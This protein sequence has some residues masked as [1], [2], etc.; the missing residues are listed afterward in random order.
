VAPRPQMLKGNTPAPRS[1]RSKIRKGCDFA[2][3]PSDSGIAA[4]N[5]HAPP[6]DILSSRSSSSDYRLLVGDL[7]LYITRPPNHAIKITPISTADVEFYHPHI[8]SLPIP[9]RNI[10]TLP[11]PQKP[12][13]DQAAL[14]YLGSPCVSNR[15]NGNRRRFPFPLPGHSAIT[16]ASH[17]RQP[18]H[19]PTKRT[20]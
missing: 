13:S 15:N 9:T 12:V 4:L 8:D 1:G 18:S 7:L 19:R 5:R 3:R 10:N 11:L 6:R 2:R 20:E 17:T 16:T 14:A